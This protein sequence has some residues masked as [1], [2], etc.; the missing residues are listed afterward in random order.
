MGVGG[1]RASLMTGMWMVL[2]VSIVAMPSFSITAFPPSRSPDAL[3]GKQNK[4]AS[5][6][7]L[8]TVRDVLPT[9]CSDIPNTA[10]LYFKTVPR[11]SF[12]NIFLKNM[13]H[14]HINC[15][16]IIC[17]AR[18]KGKKTKITSVHLLF[19]NPDD[20]SLWLHSKLIYHFNVFKNITTQGIFTYLICHFYIHC[21]LGLKLVLTQIVPLISDQDKQQ[22]TK[23]V[24]Q[25][26]IYFQSKFQASA[27]TSTLC[28]ITSTL[29]VITSIL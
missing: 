11:S 15:I 28:A 2:A 5:Q 12:R 25:H 8:L 4:S 9:G 19:Y 7:A 10:I 21:T 1:T 6:L 13:H 24:V 22:I 20:I 23:Q 26:F 29:Y 14:L 27:L 18:Q 17:N 3:R 16:H